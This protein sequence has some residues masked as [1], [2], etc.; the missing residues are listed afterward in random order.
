M[1]FIFAVSSRQSTE[2]RYSLANL[3]HILQL[4]QILDLEHLRNSKASHLMDDALDAITHWTR[5][6]VAAHHLQPFT[7][8]TL[9][10]KVFAGLNSSILCHSE[11][12]KLCLVSCRKARVWRRNDRSSLLLLFNNLQV[13]FLLLL[14]TGRLLLLSLGGRRLLLCIDAAPSNIS[15]HLLRLLYFFLSAS[16]N[17]YLSVSPAG[18]PVP[19]GSQP[20]WSPAALLADAQFAQS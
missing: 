13:L 3:W 11:S 10:L 2:A 6:P 1:V 4:H 18:L 14:V 15:L 9:Q 8:A 19:G 16:P 5:P 12:R 17:F 7:H 20:L